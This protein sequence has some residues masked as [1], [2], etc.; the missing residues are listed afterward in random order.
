MLRDGQ[1]AR[2]DRVLTTL[3]MKQI[4]RRI[5]LLSRNWRLNKMPESTKTYEILCGKYQVFNKFNMSVTNPLFS[6]YLSV[7]IQYNLLT[8]SNDTTTQEGFGV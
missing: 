2:Q 7:L 5:P 6:I 8:V 4:E 3:K 1:E